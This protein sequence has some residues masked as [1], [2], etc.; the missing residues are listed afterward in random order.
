MWSRADLKENAKVAFKR[1]YWTCVAVSVIAALLC[2]EFSSSVNGFKDGF[3]TVVGENNLFS[4]SEFF[5]VFTVALTVASMMIFI[6]S[7]CFTVFVGNVIEVGSN[8][9]YM[10]NREHQTKMTQLLYG[11][12]NGRW[13][14]V[15]LTLFLRDLYI[16]LWSLLLIVPGIIKSISYMMI[17]YLLT[18][19]PEMDKNRA[20]ELSMQMMEGHKMDAFVLWLSFFGWLLLG[21]LTCGILNLFYVKPYMDATMAEFYTAIKAEAIRKGLTSEAELPG[22]HYET[23]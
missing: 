14:N 12:R 7:I 22:Y 17:P 11:F 6:F 2:G 4:S 9:Y 8:R 10:E 16:F 3:D 23:I 20:F 1:N 19:N 5:G 15:V 21:I 13:G 18:E